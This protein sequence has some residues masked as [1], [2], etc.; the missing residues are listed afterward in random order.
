MVEEVEENGIAGKSLRANLSKKHSD[1][2][3]KNLLSKESLHP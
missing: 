3:S 1:G 2:G